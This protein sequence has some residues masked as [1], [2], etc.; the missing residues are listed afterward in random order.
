MQVNNHVSIKA[1]I[2][3]KL[4]VK[5]CA[6][7]IR[8]GHLQSGLVFYHKVEKKGSSREEEEGRHQVEAVMNISCDEHIIITSQSQ[9]IH[10]IADDHCA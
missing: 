10:I 4:L 7:N 5:S 2:F 8:I 6:H 1:H 9:L 3:T